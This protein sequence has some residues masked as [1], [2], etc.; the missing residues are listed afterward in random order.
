MYNVIMVFSVVRIWLVSI[1][2]KLPFFSQVA[3][4]ILSVNHLFVMGSSL[5]NLDDKDLWEMNTFI[6]YVQAYKNPLSLHA[7]SKLKL[8]S[9]VRFLNCFNFSHQGLKQIKTIL[10]NV[11]WKLN[12]SN[13][14]SIQSMENLQFYKFV[15]KLN[16]SFV[17]SQHLTWTFTYYVENLDDPWFRVIKLNL[18]I[19]NV[20]L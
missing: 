14:T 13:N 12:N 17:L 6:I 2:C 16:I 3:F 18:I 20:N 19:R 9:S 10:F 4:L 7:T 8:R 1:V 15:P 5:C 11:F